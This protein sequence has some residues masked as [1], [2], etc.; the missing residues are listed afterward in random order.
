M[1]YLG[2]RPVPY[3]AK[4]GTGEP[5]KVAEAAVEVSGKTE[6][7]E[8]AGEGGAKDVGEGVAP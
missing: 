6:A 5:S 8:Y 1:N 7:G 2:G 4:S 3:P